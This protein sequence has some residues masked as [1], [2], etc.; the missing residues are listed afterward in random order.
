MVSGDG[1]L[2]EQG[3]RELLPAVRY[4]QDT[5]H[6]PVLAAPC[7]YQGGFPEPSNCSFCWESG[8]FVLVSTGEILGN[9]NFQ[10]ATVMLT[11]S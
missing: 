9:A 3:L 7:R 5:L 4:G 11:I 8:S 2:T 6:Q 10:M 1:L